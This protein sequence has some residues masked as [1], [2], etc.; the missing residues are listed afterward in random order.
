CRPANPTAPD[1]G[2]SMRIRTTLALCLLAAACAPAVTPGRPGYDLIIRGGTVYDG[3]GQPPYVGDIGITGDRISAIGKLSG[4]SAQ[5]EVDASGLA[6]SPGFVNM[7]SWA[8][9]ALIHDGRSQ[10]NIR[11]GVTLE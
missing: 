10:G 7:L 4:S 6:V 5:R 2:T 1:R 9:V 11:Q 3:S 8:N